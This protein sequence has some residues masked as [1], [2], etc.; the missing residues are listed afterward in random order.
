MDRSPP[1]SSVHGILQ[2]RIL[3]KVAIPLSRG[4]FWHRDQTWVSCIAGG[5]F[6]IVVMREAQTPYRIIWIGRGQGRSSFSKCKK[7]NVIT[8]AFEI[9]TLQSA[10]LPCW[11]TRCSEELSALDQCERHWWWKQ[12]A[13]RA[14]QEAGVARA[15][16]Q[17]GVCLCT[18][19]VCR[20]S[21]ARALV[22]WPA[23]TIILLPEC[24]LCAA[25][26]RRHSPDL[27]SPRPWGGCQGWVCSAQDAGV[28]AQDH[29][30]SKWW[31]QD[32]SSGQRGLHR[33]WDS[34]VEPG[35]RE[36]QL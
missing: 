18:P 25:L 21:A 1:G 35:E 29:R 14:G 2:A 31:S 11:R 36:R 32:S 3:E 10:C 24:S 19:G 12:R 13:G 17:L 23:F 30:T 34:G 6:T 9:S 27:L 5:F 26:C 22:H 16:A 20:G 7:E 8:D 15:L 28:N 4:S 33:M